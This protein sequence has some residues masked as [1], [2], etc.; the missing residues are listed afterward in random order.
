MNIDWIIPCRFVEVHDNLGTIVG[1]GIDTLF[2]P[3]FPAP[4]Q[5]AIAIRIQALPEE[6][7]P[8]VQHTVRNVVR[9]PDGEPLSEVGGEVAFAGSQEVERPDWLQG[10]I[11][12]T[13]IAFEAAEEG[14]YAFEHTMDQSSAVGAAARRA[15][16]P[17]VAAPL[18]SP[19]AWR[20]WSGLA[21][22]SGPS[23]YAT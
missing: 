17:A 14:T 19:R 2:V 22:S 11:L 8:D 6:L 21:A 10:V 23:L 18:R 3:E 13:V 5:V 1:A 20:R 16:A 4:V 12:A 7:T 9:G 15:P